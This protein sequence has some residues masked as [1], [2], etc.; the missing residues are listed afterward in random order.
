MQPEWTIS[1]IWRLAAA[2]TS[3]GQWPTLTVASPEEKSMY[4]F[5][6]IDS[7]NTPSAFFTIM[8]VWKA[9]AGGRCSCPRFMRSLPIYPLLFPVYG[10]GLA[11]EGIV[12][13]EPA[14]LPADV[15]ELLK[16]GRTDMPRVA[17]FLFPE[18]AYI[19]QPFGP[20]V[21]K[22][23]SA[24]GEG[25]AGIA[26]VGLHILGGHRGS[27]FAYLLPNSSFWRFWS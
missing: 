24:A 14:A 21:A 5:P 26:V 23:P 22:V 19:G 25:S 7:T 16:H 4:R 17:C 12:Y 10:R 27:L 20:R 8:S 15:L 13:G 6:S 2:T 3:G 9:R 11:E 1:S 18:L